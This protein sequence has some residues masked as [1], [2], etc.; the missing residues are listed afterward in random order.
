MAYILTNDNVTKHELPV[1]DREVSAWFETNHHSTN[2]I[3]EQLNV[4]RMLQPLF[5]N[6]NDF[7]MIDLGANIGLFSLYAKGKARRIIAVE[8]TPDTFNM[9]KKLTANDPKI[10]LLQ[11]A[12]GGHD[13]QVTF[14]L[15]KET[16]INSI[17]NKVGEEITVDCYTINSIMKKFNLDYVDFIKCDIEGSEVVALTDETIG[18]VADKVGTWAIEVHQTNGDTGMPWPGNLEYNRQR[19]AQIFQR[20]GYTTEPIIHDVLLA[21][22]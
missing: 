21:W 9:L 10:E 12:A 3:L 13:G 11:G 20:H 17:V 15:N 18:A 22:K 4:E 19:I 7:T 1:A 6:L 8:P 5:E 2:I 14:F 16:T